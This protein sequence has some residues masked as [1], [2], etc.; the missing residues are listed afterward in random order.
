MSKP[1][2]NRSHWKK[3]AEIFR[4][5]SGTQSNGIS[6]NKVD[7]TLKEF[8]DADWAGDMT[9]RQSQTGF[10]IFLAE[11]LVLVVEETNNCL[12]FNHRVQV[13]KHYDNST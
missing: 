6:L 4:Y 10:L 13:Q 11:F 12:V 3:Y 9:D 5:L 8:C 7:Y 1:F 2:N